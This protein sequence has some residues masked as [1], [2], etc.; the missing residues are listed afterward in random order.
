M[1]RN[2]AKCYNDGHIGEGG[3]NSEEEIMGEETYGL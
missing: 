2:C 3:R 1:E